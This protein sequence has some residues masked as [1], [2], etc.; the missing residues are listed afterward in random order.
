MAVRLLA[1]KPAA[2]SGGRARAELRKLAQEHVADAIKELSCLA[3]A[4]ESESVRIAAIKEL[5]D[6]AYGRVSPEAEGDAGNPLELV[7]GF[8]AS[9]DAKLDRI[10]AAT[11]ADPEEKPD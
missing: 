10:I 11:N 3:E 1:A 6:R 9:L 4:A 7:I 5:L 2:R 8:G